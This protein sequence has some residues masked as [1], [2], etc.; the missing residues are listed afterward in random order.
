VI[1]AG[2]GL[3]Y[4]LKGCLH[5][6]G[7]TWDLLTTGDRQLVWNV[8][9]LLFPMRL[10]SCRDRANPCG[11]VTIMINV[12]VLAA[13]VILLLWWKRRMSLPERL[14]FALSVSFASILQI[15]CAVF[16]GI[17]VARAHYYFVPRLFL[18]LVPLRAVLAAAGAYLCVSLILQSPRNRFRLLQTPYLQWLVFAGILAVTIVT[19]TGSRRVDAEGVG[20]KVEFSV[21][22]CPPAR[23]S[24]AI[25]NTKAP[26]FVAVGQDYEHEEY[27]LNFIYGFAEHLNACGW[28]HT[29]APVVY[30]VPEYTSGN[31][32]FRYD[33]RETI[34][35]DTSIIGFV[36]EPV[37]YRTK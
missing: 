25:V 36:N 15:L 34:D 3:Y 2:V 20:E 17:L 4:G 28:T 27:K 5:Y 21:S 23:S 32:L 16:V 19:H 8:L 24:V 14:K 13:V 7:A 6:S 9:D 22:Q 12:F 26:G 10:S 11:L 31:R 29:D 33:I 18:Y 35:A 1:C 30:V 37:L